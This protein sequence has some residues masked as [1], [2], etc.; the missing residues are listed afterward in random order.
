VDPPSDGGVTLRRLFTEALGKR[1]GNKSERLKARLVAM[2]A[3][4]A[5]RIGDEFWTAE[6]AREK[7]EALVK[8]VFA[9]IRAIFD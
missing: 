7:P 3:T 2:I 6:G 5:M 1:A 4:S 9:S 8:R